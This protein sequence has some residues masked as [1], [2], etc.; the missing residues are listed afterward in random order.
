MHKTLKKL[1]G[2]GL[3]VLAV[4]GVVAPLL[5][6]DTPTRSEQA[7]GQPIYV[8]DTTDTTPSGGGDTPPPPYPIPVPPP[9]S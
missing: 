4:M 9:Q 8:T 1:L 2:L 3:L 7:A 6:A 5:A